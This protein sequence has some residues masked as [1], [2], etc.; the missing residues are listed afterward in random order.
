[1]NR[2]S[3]IKGTSIAALVS[4]MGWP[5]KASM[6]KNLSFKKLKFGICADLHYDIMPDGLD[7][8]N[9]FINQMNAE[10]VDFIIQ[11]GDFCKVNHNNKPLLDAWNKFKGPKHHV[12][13]NHDMDGGF[14]FEQVLD[15][16]GAKEPYYSFDM[17]GFHFIVLNANEGKVTTE[18]KYPSNFSNRQ[19][20]WLEKDLKITPLPSMVF[21]HQG[22]DNDS[23]VENA[24]KVRYILEQAN[25]SANGKKVH[26]VFSGHHHK[27][28]M[29]TINGIRYI[30]INS[31]SYYFIGKKYMAN[32]Y[33]EEIMSKYPKLKEVC[34]YTTP[35]WATVE[36]DATGN[37]KLN[38]Q[39][40]MFLGKS[41]KER[42]KPY[43][44]DIS[45]AASIVSDRGFKLMD[46]C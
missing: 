40:A 8:I 20:T 43:L 12:L 31:M 13:G 22:L 6:S 16:W 42:G 39:K 41:P 44:D 28:Y 18:R 27:D 19:L 32:T 15:F 1:M 33:G 9:A 36:V 34:P 5:L 7:R 21:L 24:M 37:F 11:M 29:N 14:T 35:L 46:N 26:M 10:K 45:P 25:L 4:G 17:N 3:F 2:R 30:Q 38:G 23:G